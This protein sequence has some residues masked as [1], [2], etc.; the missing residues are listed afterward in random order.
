MFGSKCYIK[1]P[2]ENRSK[3]D[4]KARE[5]RL[6][7]FKGDSI[8]MVVDPSR[9]K[10]R[11]HNVIFTEDQSNQND[12]E[13]SP[14]EFP[15]QVT[16]NSNEKDT[17]MEDQE[18]MSRQ[19][20]RSE[21]WGTDPTR[22]SEC[23]SNQVLIAKTTSDAPVPQ[24]PKA[25]ED[26][27]ESS[28]GQQWKDAMDYELTKLEEMNTWS[29]INKLD[30]SPKAQILPRMWVHLI[31]TLESK[32][33]KFRSRWV[34]QG[35]KQKTNLSLSDTFAPVSR[36]TS[37][38]ILLALATLKDMRIFAW[39]VDSAYLHGK[40]D[41]DIYVRLPDG[42]E[43]PGKVG[44]RNKALY[45]LPEAAQVWQEDLEEKLKSLGFTLLKSDC[46]IFISKTASGFTAI[47]TQVDD[48][49]GICSSKEEE[50]RI[51]CGIQKFYKIKEKNTT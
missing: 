23:I 18:D 42:Y 34:V 26:A 4:D 8:Y 49:M 28:E 39:D 9:K 15:S 30:I 50:L 17:H 48:A 38:R 31:K 32:E 11:W 22:R 47:D 46:G 29:E 41:H 40:I 13:G 44:K 24:L 14:I 7:S 25:Y 33:C 20:T 51:K 19:Q 21:V 2:D 6:I 10:L 5:C 12:K 36:I 16:E 1:V 43:K 45:G 27:V 3:L 35:D 37:L